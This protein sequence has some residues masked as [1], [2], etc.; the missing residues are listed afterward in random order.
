[1]VML[2]IIPEVNYCMDYSYRVYFINSTSPSVTTLGGYPQL[3]PTNLKNHSYSQ[4][5]KI[6]GYLCSMFLPP[7]DIG[8]CSMNYNWHSKT[9]IG[10]KFNL[11]KVLHSVLDFLWILFDMC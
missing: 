1:M 11:N 6:I 10:G 2:L 5:K 3:S 9:K 4:L 8:N 7:Q